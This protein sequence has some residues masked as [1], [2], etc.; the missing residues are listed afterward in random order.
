[1][2]KFKITLQTLSKMDNWF[3]D[4]KQFDL[5]SCEFV[6]ANEEIAEKFRKS[7]SSA[8]SIPPRIVAGSYNM[9]EIENWT[10]KLK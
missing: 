1:M 6:A 8:Y 2:K 9:T 3:G 10:E 4:V 5:V 7:I